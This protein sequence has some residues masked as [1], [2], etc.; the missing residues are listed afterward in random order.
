M[1]R[2]LWERN[3]SRIVFQLPGLDG[4]ANELVRRI[5]EVDIW[6]AGEPVGIFQ[7]FLDLGSV[8]ENPERMLFRTGPDNVIADGDGMQVKY[9]FGLIVAV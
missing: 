4:V 6:A 5:L 7:E 2:Q 8:D 1:R 9:E 3:F